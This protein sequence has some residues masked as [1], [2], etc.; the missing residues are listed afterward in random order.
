MA[1]KCS[2]ISR[3]S[4]INIAIFNNEWGLY[5]IPVS[6]GYIRSKLHP[7]NASQVSKSHKI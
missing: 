3:V 7:M 1:L 2:T 6:G 5:I 4:R